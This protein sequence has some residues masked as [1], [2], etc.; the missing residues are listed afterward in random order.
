MGMTSTAIPYAQ[1]TQITQ[2]NRDRVVTASGSDIIGNVSITSA[3]PI[4]TIQQYLIS[5]LNFVGTRQYNLAQNFQR[6]RYKRLSFTIAANQPSTAGGAIFAGYTSNP[7]QAFT[8]V[9]GASSVTN[10]NQVFNLPGAQLVPMF[11]PRTILAK[12]EDASKWYYLDDDSD[13]IMNTTCGQFVY[14][15]Q[16]VSNITGTTSIPIIMDYEIE[17][18]GSAT[19]VQNN[20]LPIAFP[21]TLST[22]TNSPGASSRFTLVALTGEPAVPSLPINTLYSVSPGWEVSVV[23]DDG[24]TTQV[25]CKS[26]AR[27]TPSSGSA[28]TYAVYRTVGDYFDSVELNVVDA[29]TFPR[30]TLSRFSPGN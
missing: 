14:T 1:A 8:V 18:V 20:G 7:D 21:A 17:F 6:Y 29:Q 9:P 5:P 30:S 22:S 16:S 12:I 10:L 4:G 13:E 26:L 28:V 15:V 3:T 25:L 19:L 23:G 27:V 11:V 2:K 24:E